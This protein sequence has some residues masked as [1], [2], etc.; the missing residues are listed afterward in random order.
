MNSVRRASNLVARKLGAL[1][2]AARRV[3]P[4]ALFVG[5]LLA[6]VVVG[7]A[8][9][10]RK[11]GHK[12][13]KKGKGKG[14]GGKGD[15]GAFDG[16]IKD[17][18]CL[19]N[20]QAVTN[21]HIDWGFTPG[22]AAYACNQWNSTC[23]NGGGCTA[24]PNSDVLKSHA[25]GG[26]CTD[27][28]PYADGN[29]STWKCV[30]NPDPTQVGNKPYAWVCK[31]KGGDQS[32]KH[33]CGGVTRPHH[34]QLCQ[35]WHCGLGPDG[36]ETWLCQ[37]GAANGKTYADYQTL[38]NATQTGAPAYQAPAPAPTNPL[39]DP[40]RMGCST[41]G[42]SY[43]NVTFDG[44]QCCQGKDY[45][46]ACGKTFGMDICCEGPPGNMDKKPGDPGYRTC[47][48]DGHTIGEGCNGKLATS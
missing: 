36:K 5:V 38:Y 31:D 11:E 20:G 14:K 26:K 1:V 23:G 48:G 29:C 24:V 32:S 22:D 45:T 2:P 12:G 21:V 41:K 25:K 4:M 35:K 19:L 15:K 7:W 6:L 33:H 28:K 18:T 17:W 27:A 46:G 30:P 9:F 8:L 16:N 40:N 13:H 3:D 37:R 44:T 39:T 47:P 43:D 42:T 34:T 10:F